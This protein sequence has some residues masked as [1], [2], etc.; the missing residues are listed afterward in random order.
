MK[1][2][3]VDKYKC[4]NRCGKQAAFVAGMSKVCSIDCAKE[5]AVAKLNKKKKADQATANKRSRKEKQDI[6]P[7]A[8]ICREAQKVV[9][10]MVTTIDR[11]M[12]YDCIATNQKI[13]DAGHYYH[14]GSKYRIS[15]LRFMHFNIHGQGAKSNRYGRGTEE[16]E[17]YAAGLVSRY[18]EQYLTDL[19]EFKRM[20]DSGMV[21]A[22]TREEVAGMVKWCRAMTKIYKNKVCISC[23]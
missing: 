7:M 9:N 14:A 6:K 17:D 5:L 12:G 2:K 10:T 20:T 18:N 3:A 15:W 21:P 1:Q 22:P 23:G 4:A 16:A 8:T 13:S 19:R 11:G